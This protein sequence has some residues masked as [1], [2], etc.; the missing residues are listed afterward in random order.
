MARHNPPTNAF[1]AVIRYCKEEN[2]CDMCPLR[3]TS[4][5]SK[6]G[7]SKCQFKPREWTIRPVEEIN[8]AWKRRA[9]CRR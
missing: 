1:R 9:I 4:L 6:R 2:N 3:E 7:Y 5:L 8:D